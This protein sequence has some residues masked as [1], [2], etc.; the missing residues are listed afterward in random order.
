MVN[1]ESPPHDIMKFI[2]ESHLTGSRV[3]SGEN[4]INCLLLGKYQ[5]QHSDA[6][7]S[8]TDGMPHVNYVRLR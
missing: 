3:L 1:I 7:Q 8:R 4:A 2:W 6:I 5:A